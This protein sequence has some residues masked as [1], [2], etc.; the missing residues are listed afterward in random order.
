[1][2]GI[3]RES[4]NDLLNYT[5]LRRNYEKYIY[6]FSKYKNSDDFKEPIPLRDITKERLKIHLSHLHL[7]HRSTDRN[8]NQHRGSLG[9]SSNADTTD[10]ANQSHNSHIHFAKLRKQS[11]HIF[12]SITSLS[13]EDEDSGVAFENSTDILNM[14]FLLV[15]KQHRF[16]SYPK[17]D[18]RQKNIE[19]FEEIKSLG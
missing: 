8:M 10:E 14:D 1:M 2:P 17:L 7:H 18:F 11:R 19:V 12:G 3:R 13:K 4:L 15:N 5:H 16:I 9:F 6:L